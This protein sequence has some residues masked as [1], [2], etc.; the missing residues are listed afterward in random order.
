MLKI[1]RLNRPAL[2]CAGFLVLVALFAFVGPLL[3][4]AAGL[5]GVSQDARLGA[6]PP[7]WRHWLGTDIL[8]RDLLVRTLE[9]RR[10]A[11]VGRVPPALIASAISGAWR[12]ASRAAARS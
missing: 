11:L 8:G 2:A 5:D 9:G 7:S 3:A 1:S 10:S 6:S 4:S 12:A